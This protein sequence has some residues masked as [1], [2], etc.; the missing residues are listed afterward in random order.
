MY[1]PVN[2]NKCLL[3]AQLSPSKRR[4]RLRRSCSFDFIPFV[5]DTSDPGVQQLKC[6]ST[7]HRFGTCPKSTTSDSQNNYARCRNKRCSFPVSVTNN[8]YKQSS[9]NSGRTRGRNSD[10]TTSANNQQ[11][12]P[13]CGWSCD[14]ALLISGGW[15]K[16]T[17]RM[18]HLYNI[19]DIYRHLNTKR[20]FDEKNIKVFFA[21]NST[22][23]RKWNT[24]S[25]FISTTFTRITL[26][27][28][29]FCKFSIYIQ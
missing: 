24:F 16:Y 15:S 10:T 25:I 20:S 12:R 14:Y 17:N 22:I 5:Y 26:N 19:Q 7:I 9:T 8:N 29:R 23:E 1:L 2:N 4:E 13:T 3:T 21:N 11:N 28:G 27:H 6:Y 18:R